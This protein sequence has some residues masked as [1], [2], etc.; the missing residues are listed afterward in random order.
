MYTNWPSCRLRAKVCDTFLNPR[1]FC[2]SSGKERSCP[3]RFARSETSWV[4]TVW[5]ASPIWHCLLAWRRFPHLSCCFWVWQLIWSR[6]RRSQES[7][8]SRVLDS[9]DS[10][11][12]VQPQCAAVW[13]SR[14]KAFRLLKC[15]T[16]SRRRGHG[17][18][19]ASC[20]PTRCCVVTSRR[21][22]M[23]CSAGLCWFLH[24]PPRCFHYVDSPQ[25]FINIL[26]NEF[27]YWS[28]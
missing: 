17:L 7:Y 5:I 4:R 13:V 9:I 16:S 8:E 27:I 26:K 15:G 24:P 21:C 1:K 25:S 20:S 22:A 3:L 14:L 19:C 12:V 10:N 6:P 23:N 2:S 18:W 11:W 28:I